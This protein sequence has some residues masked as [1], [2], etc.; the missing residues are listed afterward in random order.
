MNQDDL[1]NPKIPRKTDKKGAPLANESSGRLQRLG[2]PM[3]IRKGKAVPG[4]EV[5][6]PNS[7]TRTQ[8]G[9]KQKAERAAAGVKTMKPEDEKAL[10]KRW[11]DRIS[12]AVKFR[13]RRADD[14]GWDKF[15]REY[16]GK[17]DV[18]IGGNEVPP[19]NEVFAYV[20]TSNSFL[21]YRDPY[22][23]INPRK[24]STIKGAKILETAINYHWRELKIKEE[25]N[26]ELIDANL[27][28]H[29][30]NKTGINVQTEGDGDSFM[31]T[32][33][34]LYSR[35]VSWRDVVFNVG[36]MNPPDDCVWMA[37]RIIRPLSLIKKLYPL[38]AGMKGGP[39]PNLREDEFKD[40]VFKDDIEFGV[41]WEIWDS[42]TR[43]VLLMG[44][45]YMDHLLK[46]VMP[47][48]DY[49][50]TFPFRM[51]WFDRTPDESYPISQ[52]KTWNPQI[53][54][55]IKLL[56]MSLNHV[57]RWNR[58]LLMLKGGLDE[59]E[60]DKFE[61]GIDGAMIFTNKPPAEVAV[62][63]V[64]APLPPDIY[65]LMD[66]L[67]QIKRDINGQPEMERGGQTDTQT[68][69]LGELRMI[70]GGA[71]GRNDKKQGSFESHL[72]NI[73]RDLIEH[74]KAHFDLQRTVQI[75]G[76][77]PQDVIDAFGDNYNPETRSI[78][79]TKD[80]IQGE[81][82][83]NVKAGSTLPLNR[84]NRMAV[85]NQ[86]LQISSQLA[87]APTIP[88][89]V[90]V[91]I[92]EMLRDFDIKALDQA[93]DAQEQT[94]QQTQQMQAQAAQINQSK[95]EAEASK[96]NAQAKEINV[97]TL[98]KGGAALQRLFHSLPADAKPEAVQAVQ[99]MLSGTQQPGGP[100]PV[101][102]PAQ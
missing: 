8:H 21:N 78:T 30:W 90:A 47:W 13:D 4:H 99:G 62:P 82:D 96:R 55:S 67:D 63:L 36:S 100:P 86:V 87:A 9:T 64:Y 46:P 37:Q 15:I 59:G 69:T 22:I 76:E 53:L 40:T 42:E 84:N 73:A 71:Q 27:I 17:Y 33:E 95:T 52:I 88:P 32:H 1:P 102:G 35:R 3:K 81:Y 31:V 74:M 39:H 79:F 51:I 18:V 5:D 101:G 85:L 6:A 38:A 12:T 2:E 20:Q 25:V 44:D 28:G 83:I 94:T 60:L 19:I 49:V 54:E 98:I 10:I 26:L 70:Q 93:F 75:T 57:K 45:G 77:M 14:E 48:A 34:E 50:K 97:D 89:F 23:A 72:E 41:M 68:R 11:Q 43:T 16:K 65:N 66:R 91:V 80:D 61:K 24:E 56:A 7:K 92:K 58:Q 29:G